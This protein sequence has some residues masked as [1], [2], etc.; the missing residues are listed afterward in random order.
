MVD[1][2]LGQL[3]LNAR[4]RAE[5]VWSHVPGLVQ[6]LNPHT[7]ARNALAKLS[8]KKLARLKNAQVRIS[9]VFV[10]KLLDPNLPSIKPLHSKQGICVTES[11]NQNK[12]CSPPKFKSFINLICTRYT[13]ERITDNF[14]SAFH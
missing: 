2:H 4:K 14:S 6:T 7:V 12:S 10:D 9:Y 13:E 5:K 8:I 3:S 11:E 1:S